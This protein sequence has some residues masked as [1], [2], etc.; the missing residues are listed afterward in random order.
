MNRTEKIVLVCMVIL[1]SSDMLSQA[2]PPP[3]P[4]PPPPGLALGIGEYFFLLVGLVFG[5]KQ[6]T[7]KEEDSSPSQEQ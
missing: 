5:V 2:V 1:W 4:P 7:K 3:I 6:I